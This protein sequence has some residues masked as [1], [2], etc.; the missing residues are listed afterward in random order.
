[1]S[2]TLNSN[3]RRILQQTINTVNNLPVNPK[4]GKRPTIKTAFAYAELTAQD[5]NGLWSAFEVYFDET[6]TPNELTDGRVWGLEI[7]SIIVNG[8][9]SAG[10]VIRV[11]RY[12][13][14]DSS[15]DEQPIW[16]GSA[17]GGGGVTNPT[18][19]IVQSDFTINNGFAS[20][21]LVK[22]SET[23]EDVSIVQRKFP[24]AQ[25]FQDEPLY[26][27]LDSDIEGSKIYD[28]SAT[29]HGVGSG[30]DA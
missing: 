9:V 27:W 19:L 3:D 10:T 20:P 4:G 24:Q 29:L 22:V 14:V 21:V 25:F 17:V 16:I 7:P 11:E 18:R 30:I 26:G 13:Y 1:M 15:N 12:Y 8:T 28:V 6:G 23:G 5:A 2:Y